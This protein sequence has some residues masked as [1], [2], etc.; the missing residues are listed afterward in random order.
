MGG[1]TG[2]ATERLPGRAVRRRFLEVL[3]MTANVTRA[4]REAGMG[5]RCFYRLRLGDDAFRTAW[6][7]ALEEGCRQVEAMLLA[8]ALGEPLAPGVDRKQV[9]E[10]LARR[11]AR[12]KGAPATVRGRQ[13]AIETVERSLLRKLDALDRRRQRGKEG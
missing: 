10:M 3:G 4:A 5:T 7:A 13:V 12:G 11:E 6:D 2:A 9:L 8:A 1:E